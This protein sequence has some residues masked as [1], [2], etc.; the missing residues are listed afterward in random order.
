MFPPAS[1]SSGQ[2]QIVAD[3]TSAPFNQVCR[4]I[5]QFTNGSRDIATGWLLGFSTVV[6]AAHVFDGSRQVKSIEVCPGFG[7]GRARFGRQDTR[8]F[9]R[10]ANGAD[11][12]AVFLSE[13]VDLGTFGVRTFD[14]TSPPSVLSV[15]GYTAGDVGV[16][17]FMGS[18]AVLS[19]AGD[20]IQY[21]VSTV[22]GNSGGPVFADA[23][24]FVVAVHHDFERATPIT[25]QLFDQMS[26]WRAH[27]PTAALSLGAMTPRGRVAA[28]TA[29]PAAVPV[30]RLE[31]L[32]AERPGPSMGP[33]RMDAAR[34]VR[35]E[36]R[37]P[38]SAC[39]S[40]GRRIGA[41]VAADLADAETAW[42]T[43]A[44][45]SPGSALS[46]SGECVLAG[47]GQA[48]AKRITC[49]QLLGGDTAHTGTTLLRIRL[50]DIPTPGQ[51]V[52]CSTLLSA[53]DTVR[54][55][56]A[57]SYDDLVPPSAVPD[58]Q[59]PAAV[60]DQPSADAPSG[61]A[62]SRVKRKPRSKQGG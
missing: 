54:A 51:P 61:P 37:L 22:N 7:G 3:T 50:D 43:I 60:D 9:E 42:V 10:A 8:L 20:P 19:A 56:R 34:P 13:R 6:T 24:L 57:W 55:A 48:L 58:R 40:L 53:D 36:S 21:G 38:A 16:N 25:D 62:T 1:G 41:A 27:V 12:A 33:S 5:I 35:A 31:A 4:L 17:Q 11:C 26:E 28:P 18:G 59:L 44:D 32:D 49:P 52:A 15:L 47:M 2:L 39:E 14:P 29:R 46:F 30:I 45:A 23:E